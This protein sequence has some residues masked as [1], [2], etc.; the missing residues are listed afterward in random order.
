MSR[1]T[2]VLVMAG[3]VTLLTACDDSTTLPGGSV[4]GG[5]GEQAGVPDWSGQLVLGEEALTADDASTQEELPGLGHKF[6][7]LLAMEEEV[8][9]Q[10]PTNEVIG[11]TTTPEY[12]AGAGVAVRNLPP[13]LRITALE[14]QINLKY[15]FPANR[16]CAGGSPRIQLAI[17]RDGDR[18]PDGNAFGYVG[19]LPFGAGCVTG[20]W[21]IID[22]TD[23]VGRWDLSQFG[24]GMTMR[25]DE[26]E[27]FFTTVYPNHR[28]LSGALVD[29]SCSF[30]PGACGEAFYDLVTVENRTLENWQDAV[31]RKQ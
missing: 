29:D 24:G 5:G 23:Q 2:M 18:E 3:A 25:W 26:V 21:D 1:L 27:A 10:N 31:E 30:A 13:G 7:L 4:P 16:T 22:M 19:H 11:I 14:N 8:D 17:S 6:Q 20:D 28:V 12:P 15:Y 9:P